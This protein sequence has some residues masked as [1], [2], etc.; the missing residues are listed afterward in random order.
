MCHRGLHLLHPNMWVC[1]VLKHFNQNV[2]IRA[3]TESY[4]SLLF[5]AHDSSGHKLSVQ[6]MAC[7][8]LKGYGE[9]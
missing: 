4:S 2:D 3:E 5:A 7:R 1:A 9:G 8:S 6:I